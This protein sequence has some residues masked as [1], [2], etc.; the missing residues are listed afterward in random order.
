MFDSRTSQHSR[1]YSFNSVGIHDSNFK[2][3]Q[4]CILQV[5]I[6]YSHI[7]VCL[8]RVSELNPEE[9]RRNFE[10]DQEEASKYPLPEQDDDI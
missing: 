3:H 5:S 4:L 6:A 10:K 8:T 9:A 2:K 7:I 1:V